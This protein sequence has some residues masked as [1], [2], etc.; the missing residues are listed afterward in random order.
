MPKLYTIVSILASTINKFSEALYN[1]PSNKNKYI[2]RIFEHIDDC[3]NKLKS[4]MNERHNLLWK[5][6]ARNQTEIIDFVINTKY[7]PNYTSSDMKFI[8]TGFYGMKLSKRYLISSFENLKIYE[9]KSVENCTKVTGIVSRF[10][11]STKHSLIL[12]LYP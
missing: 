8:S 5:L 3:E 1:N 4:L 11:S 2:K 6:V 10:V 9:H 7:L 12:K